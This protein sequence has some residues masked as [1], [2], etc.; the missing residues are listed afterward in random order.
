MPPPP[1]S[2]TPLTAYLCHLSGIICC[3]AYCINR[4]QVVITKGL[5]RIYCKGGSSFCW[6]VGTHFLQGFRGVGIDILQRFRGGGGYPFFT[7][8]KKKHNMAKCPFRAIPS[9]DFTRFAPTALNSFRHPGGGGTHFLRRLRGRGD[10]FF[11]CN[12][13]KKYHPPPN[14]KFWTVSK[15]GRISREAR[16][17][18]THSWCDFI[19]NTDFT[20]SD[21][22]NSTAS[23]SAD[24]Y[25]D[26]IDSSSTA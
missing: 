21:P 9:V 2:K 3:D 25:P 22:T 8:T 13:P 6:G 15:L 24:F 17:S 12:F 5:F 26:S 20:D 16:V 7:H 4:S 11:T 10:A 18:V 1:H 19:Y 14:K 23:G